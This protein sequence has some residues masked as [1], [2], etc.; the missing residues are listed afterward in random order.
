MAPPE[1]VAAVLRWHDGPVLRGRARTLTA[2]APR[3]LAATTLV[4]ALL[5]AGCTA[6][7]PRPDPDTD[8]GAAAV[9]AALADGLS[10]EDVAAVA[11]SGATGAAVD[12]QLQPLVAGMGPLA[13]TVTVTGVDG[14]G[15]TATATLHHRWT[16]P[17]V[18]RPWEYDTTAEL[19]HEDGSWRARWQPSL[20]EPSL[21]ATHRLSQRRLYPE[22]GEVL[23][24]DGEPLVTLRAVVRVGIDKSAVSGAAATRSAQRLARLVDVDADDYLAAV[25]DAGAEAFVPAITLRAEADERPSGAQ[26][27]AIPGALAIEDEQ[28]LAPSRTFARAVLGTVGEAT[29]DQVDAS[30]GAVVAG[31][32]VGL[33][34]LQ[35]RYDAE[36]RGTPGVQV[37]RAELA[38]TGGA[39]PSPS[40]TPSASPTPG[41][42]LFRVE[43]VAG[44]PLET[45]LNRGLQELGERVLARTRPAS[46][47]VAIRPSTGAVVAAAH[48]PGAGDQA[49]ATT[50]Q[51]PPGSTFKVITSLALLRA[52][53]TPDSTVSCPATLTVDGFR[54]KNYSDYPSSALGR[55]DLRTAVAQSCNTAFIGQRGTVEDGELAA[56]AA[57]LGVGTDYDVGFPSFFGAVPQEKS[58]TGRGAAMI[59]QAKDQASPMAMAAV[60]ASVQAGKTV[61]PHLVE[62]RQAEPEAEPLT[63]EEAAQLRQLMR[64]VVTEG[65]GRGVLGDLDGPA[66]IAKTGT[67][68]YGDDE[69]RKTHA[70]MIAAQGDLAVAVFVAEGESGSR[71]AG[72]LLAS[73]L[74]GAR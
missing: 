32:Q 2:T 44:K 8:S 52:G 11:F 22:R 57:S 41:P 40:P 66:V 61:V 51:F 56:A 29:K 5:L 20:V 55:I 33:S 69:P 59:G 63:S 64:A 49:L 10:R 72:P 16:F 9:A 42:P 3:R 53:L 47:L 50:G 67:A 48:G 14:S 18:P 70:W 74:R 71:T 58:Q 45:T 68:E 37:V 65:S 13:P 21:D 34:G 15:D 36:L 27:R 6:T 17:G 4:A 30:E 26:V 39:S 60:A 73:F 23:G 35:E 31:D 24:Q 19:V 28:M 1:R 7:T 38:P 12:E 62:G 54:F 43:P 25:A 46:A